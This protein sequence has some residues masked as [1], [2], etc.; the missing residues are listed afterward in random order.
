MKKL[1]WPVI[2]IGLLI[3]S[4]LAWMAHSLVGWGGNL[5]SSNADIVTPVPEAVEW[6]SWIALF[7]T[8]LIEWLVIGIWAIGVVIALAIGFAGNR[9]LPHVGS[10]AS[11]LRPRS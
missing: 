11:R 3:W 5:A 4:G 1:V 6:M 7:S 8:N 2:A 10:L 9:L